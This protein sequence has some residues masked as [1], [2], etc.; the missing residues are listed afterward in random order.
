MEYPIRPALAGSGRHGTL[1]VTR[2]RQQGSRE[3][4][5]GEPGGAADPARDG[6]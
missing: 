1:A 5:R 6:G 3:A 4:S 2:M